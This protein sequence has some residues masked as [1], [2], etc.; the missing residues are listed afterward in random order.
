MSFDLTISFDKAEYL[1]PQLYMMVDTLRD[2]I[3]DD[4][5]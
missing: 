5:I 3:P 1:N 4:T 2:N